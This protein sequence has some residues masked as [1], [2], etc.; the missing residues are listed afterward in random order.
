MSKSE[1]LISSNLAAS[2][3]PRHSSIRLPQTHDEA[4]ESNSDS[5]PSPMP[6][7]RSIAVE[8]RKPSTIA[9]AR[10]SVQRNEVDS[11]SDGDSTPMRIRRSF[12][13]K[14]A[15][16]PVFN[17]KSAPELVYEEV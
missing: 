10:Q 5:E 12:S 7:R 4:N 11:D 2:N 13:Q 3:Q 14:V 9:P 15:P 17:P 1:L 16:A 8:Q 6:V